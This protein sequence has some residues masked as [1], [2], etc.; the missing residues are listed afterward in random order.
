MSTLS[1][2][3]LLTIIKEIL[4]PSS[5]MV[6]E[7]SITGFPEIL[8]EIIA[9]K[10]LDH[11]TSETLR[12][13]GA[14]IAKHAAESGYQLSNLMSVVDDDEKRSILASLALK[15][16]LWNQRDCRKV[17]TKL[18]QRSPKRYSLSLNEQIKAAEKENN[19]SL[20]LELLRKKQE[21]AVSNEKQ[22][23]KI[24]SEMS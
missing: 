10:A 6:A 24:S 23:M 21:L 3:C 12:S 16:E 11:F 22:K 19:Q 5:L 17:I 7:L 20:L 9:S 15:E 2:K 4:L 14:V 8:P 18:V 13:L 1:E